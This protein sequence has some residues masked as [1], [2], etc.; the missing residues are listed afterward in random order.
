MLARQGRAG[1]LIAL[2]SREVYKLEQGENKVQRVDDC[3]ITFIEVETRRVAHPHDDALVISLCVSNMTI[4][5]ILVD[6]GST[7]NIIFKEA[8]DQLVVGSI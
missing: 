6:N 7:V 3:C 5:R 2:P 1:S 8:F 4:C